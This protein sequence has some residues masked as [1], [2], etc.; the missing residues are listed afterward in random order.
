MMLRDGPEKNTVQY[1]PDGINFEVKALLAMPPTAPGPFCP[2]AFADNGDGRG[3]TWGLYHITPDRSAGRNESILARFDC[4]LSRDVNRPI[5]KRNNLR[6]NEQTYL[7]RAMVLGGELKKSIIEERE[8]VDRD[9][10]GA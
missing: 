4:D 3:I 7:Q 5:F 8:K 9:T 2:D 10:I 1:A 6:F